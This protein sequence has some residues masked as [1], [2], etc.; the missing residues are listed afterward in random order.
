MIIYIEITIQK[1]IE[2]L[3]MKFKINDYDENRI[4]IQIKTKCEMIINDD[5]IQ[6]IEIYASIFNCTFENHQ[7]IHETITLKKVIMNVVDVDK[8]ET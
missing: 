7:N 4:A 6:N 2:K 5:N 8:S 1:E 3:S